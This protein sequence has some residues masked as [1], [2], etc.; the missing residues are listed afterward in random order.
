M[1]V[2]EDDQLNDPESIPSLKKTANKNLSNCSLDELKKMLSFNYKKRSEYSDKER[3]TTKIIENIEYYV[4][5]KCEHEWEYDY[6]DPIDGPDKI[7]KKC[8]LYSNHF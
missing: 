1:N 5:H 4:F 2:I 3:I 8:H 7:C 6:S